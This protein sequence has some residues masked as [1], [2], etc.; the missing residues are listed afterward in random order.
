MQ[1]EN[2]A[3]QQRQGHYPELEALSFFREQIGNDQ[4]HINQ[5]WQSRNGRMLLLTDG[6]VSYLAIK[7]INGSSWYKQNGSS[8][9]AQ[10]LAE[11][12]TAWAGI[13]EFE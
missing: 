13:P 7:Y 10:E 4:L 12:V 5:Q 6:E 9:D 8:F 3:D 2:Q 11:Q 1:Q